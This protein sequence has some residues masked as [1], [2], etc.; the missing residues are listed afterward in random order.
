MPDIVLWV[1]MLLRGVYETALGYGFDYESP[2]E[3][4]FILKLLET[5]MLTGKNWAKA[6]REIDNAIS[7]E[8]LIVPDSQTL[9]AQMEKTS[10]AFATDVMVAKF[11]QG[12]PLVG[13]VGGALNP[14]Y[15][16]R[17]MKY[18]QLKYRKRYLL[19]K[20]RSQ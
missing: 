4:Y 11:I 6:N 16:N 17:V 15:Y 1:G 13:V 5:S 14:I 9:S 20:L 2:E 8:T 10:N 12:L 18:V 7:K 19:K 3:K